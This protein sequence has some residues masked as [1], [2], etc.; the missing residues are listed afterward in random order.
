M[1]PFPFSTRRWIKAHKYKIPAAW[2]FKSRNTAY[3]PQAMPSSLDRSGC[4]YSEYCIHTRSRFQQGTSRSVRWKVKK[5]CELL[6]SVRCCC[7]CNFIFVN[8]NVSIWTHT[9]KPAK[10]WTNDFPQFINDIL[11]TWIHAGYILH[12][13]FMLFFLF[14][15]SCCLSGMFGLRLNFCVSLS[16]FVP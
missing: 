11:H 2:H 4:I 12:V 9:F 14:K 8:L 10:L 3:S 5:M 13:V 6:M 15:H 7:L 16:H 1:N